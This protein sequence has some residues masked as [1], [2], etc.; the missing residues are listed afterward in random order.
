[1]NAFTQRGKVLQWKQ[2]ATSGPS[3]RVHYSLAYNSDTKRTLLFG[4]FDGNKRL[5]DLWSW[6][7][8]AWKEIKTAIRPIARNAAAIAYDHYRK[9]LVL[10]GGYA[11]RSMPLNDTWEFDGKN[12]KKQVPVPQREGLVMP[13]PMMQNVNY[14]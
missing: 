9:R 4:G 8:V 12:W 13:W 5:N 11:S 10:Y 7:G 6:D 14:A 1:L 3:P 2:V